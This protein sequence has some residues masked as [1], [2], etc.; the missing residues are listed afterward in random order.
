LRRLH[1]GFL[2]VQLG[3]KLL[4]VLNR[5]PAVLRQGLVTFGLLLRKYERGM[6]LL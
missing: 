3:R 5:T 1:R 4:R 6:A 2:L